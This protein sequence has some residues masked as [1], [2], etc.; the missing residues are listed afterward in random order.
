MMTF[1]YQ[2]LSPPSPGHSGLKTLIPNHKYTFPKIICYSAYY[3]HLHK[4]A[5][6]ELPNAQQKAKVLFCISKLNRKLQMKQ[7][8]AI[9]N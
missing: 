8:E 3:G 9:G 4:H 2:N 6:K 1:L 5:Y 7:Q